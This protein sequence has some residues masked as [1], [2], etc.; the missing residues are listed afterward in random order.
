M[1]RKRSCSQGSVTA[2]FAVVLPA[3]TA[4]LAFLLLGAG[5]GLLQLRLE[6]GARAGARAMARGEST[7]QAREATLRLAGEH[8]SVMIDLDG[9]YATV[10]VAGNAQGPFSGLLPWKQTA[11]ATA[12]IEDYTPDAGA[13][14]R[15]GEVGWEVSLLALG[16]QLGDYAACGRLCSVCGNGPASGHGAAEPRHELP[17]A[18]GRP[19]RGNA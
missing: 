17:A 11:Q 8:V 13:A 1:A 15:R 4:L 10:T 7:E 19:S 14:R 3:V 5:A 12:K 16:G 2:E 18:Q 6:E 9:G